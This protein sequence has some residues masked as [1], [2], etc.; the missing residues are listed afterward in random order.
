MKKAL[1]NTMLT[2]GAALAILA[3]FF[4]II[5]EEDI[6]I[7]TV[8]EILGANI[9]INFGLFIR[10]KFEIRNLFLDFITDVSYIIIVLLIFG[11]IFDWYSTIPVWLLPA[12]AVVIYIFVITTNIVKINKDTKEINE[13]LQK[14]NEKDVSVL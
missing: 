7:R 5:G 14:R 11:V 2:T 4:L 10:F 3:V 9:F 13:L 12:M 8:F 6:P 1:A